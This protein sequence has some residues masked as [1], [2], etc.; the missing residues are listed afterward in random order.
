MPNRGIWLAVIARKSPSRT[1]LIGPISPVNV[2]SR[3]Q[4]V[5]SRRSSFDNRENLS[6]KARITYHKY[7]D[8]I[9]ATN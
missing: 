7:R 6:D 1:N 3:K 5:N 4:F 8:H 9:A 2:M